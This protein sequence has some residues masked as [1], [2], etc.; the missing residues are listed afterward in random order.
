MNKWAEI[1]GSRGENIDENDVDG[2]ARDIGFIGTRCATDL[3]DDFINGLLGSGLLEDANLLGKPTNRLNKALA[4]SSNGMYKKAVQ[5]SLGAMRMMLE[6]IGERD[7][8]VCKD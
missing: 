5:R 6:K 7:L 3:V 1:A 4:A 8:P 2:F